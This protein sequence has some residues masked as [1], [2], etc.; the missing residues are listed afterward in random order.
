VAQNAWLPDE[1]RPVVYTS[2]IHGRKQELSGEAWE[3]RLE[4]SACLELSPELFPESV[5]KKRPAAAPKGL[6]PARELW[7]WLRRDEAALAELLRHGH[8]VVAGGF[9]T[10]R[11]H[12]ALQGLFQR[13]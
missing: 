9:L 4:L 11:Q 7:L 1:R 13:K 5:K 3:L 2:S 12:E 6:V 8:V 10:L